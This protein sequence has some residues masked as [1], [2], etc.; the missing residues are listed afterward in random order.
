MK[1]TEFRRIAA[2][3]Q[4]ASKTTVQVCAD[5]LRGH[6]AGYR[7]V[8]SLAL[9]VKSLSVKIIILSSHLV[10]DNVSVTSHNNMYSVTV[11]A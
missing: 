2:E 11:R 9:K 3:W 7:H 10:C 4:I 6:N 5:T 8:A 1:Q